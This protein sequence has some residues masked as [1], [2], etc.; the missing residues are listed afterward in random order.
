MAAVLD[1]SA[2][3]EDVQNWR[4]SL[5]AEIAKLEAVNSPLTERVRRLESLLYQVSQTAT[6]EVLFDPAGPKHVKAI[7]M[8]LFRDIQAAV[9]KQEKEEWI[10]R[11]ELWE[12][13][14]NAWGFVA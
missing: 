4:S 2:Y 10:R 5:A 6:H 7:P 1:G 13:N 12:R 14:D 8:D 3:T 11:S 9:A